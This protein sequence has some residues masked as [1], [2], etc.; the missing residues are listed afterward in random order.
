MSKGQKGYGKHGKTKGKFGKTK[1]KFSKGKKGK[2]GWGKKGIHE[3]AEPS[4]DV[5]Q[6]VAQAQAEASVDASAAVDP[7]WGEESWDQYDPA[8]AWQEED[9]WY[10]DGS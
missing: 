5:T 2:K 4:S 3:L 9:S 6:N 1:G 7:V 8:A 10:D